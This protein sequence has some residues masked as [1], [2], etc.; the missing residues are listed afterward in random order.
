[1]SHIQ[2]LLDKIRE[3]L[4]REDESERLKTLHEKLEARDT[5]SHA[6]FLDKRESNGKRQARLERHATNFW[7]YYYPGERPTEVTA[8]IPETGHE[9]WTEAQ[10]RQAR[11][12]MI[13]LT[14]AAEIS[15]EHKRLTSTDKIQ[16]HWM[17]E[18]MV[19]E[20]ALEKKDYMEAEKCFKAVL[21]EAE[22]S[23]VPDELLAKVMKHLARSL[24]AQRK[25]G[26]FETVYEKAILTC[27]EELNDGQYFPEEEELNRIA[28]EYVKE[29]K[30]EE[31]IELY[32]HVLSVLERVRG[33]KSAVVSRCLNDLA[34]IYAST[35]DMQK[36]E[37]LLKRAID[38]TEKSP[39]NLSAEMATSLYNLGGL[40]QKNDRNNEAQ[41]LFGRA[42]AILERTASTTEAS[43]A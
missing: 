25:Y 14:S 16:Q 11:E 21:I 35:G 10:H 39:S 20:L 32:Q 24:S 17:Y 33:P 18:S 38:I 1:M 29:G 9:Q 15:E 23:R 22:R 30:E 31:A 4:Y 26:E 40:Y 27:P 43:H 36:A 7:H 34:G 28:C 12:R 5:E 2:Q 37:E 3:R 42:M 41:E 13:D 6:D 19:G 8:E